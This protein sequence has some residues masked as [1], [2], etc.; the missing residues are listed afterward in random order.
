MATSW[1]YVINDGSGSPNIVRT[2]DAGTTVTQVQPGEYVV[3]LPF[4]V[5]GLA[6]VGTL[7]NS[8]GTITAIPGDNSGLSANQVR[9][10]TLSLQN[11]ALGSYDFSLAVF[12]PARRPWW[13]WVVG[14]II[15]SV[16]YLLL[17][18]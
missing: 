2:S 3:T 7:N 11:Q 4:A 10:V 5:S 13:P 15:V 16:L 1:L 6:C 14:A 12:Y 9:V 17:R 18:Q 8:V